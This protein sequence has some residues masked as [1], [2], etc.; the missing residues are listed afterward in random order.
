[1]SFYK[2][3]IFADKVFYH[4]YPLGLSNAPRNND[5]SQPAGNAFEVLESDLDRIRNLGVNALYM[6]PLF[7]STKHGYD[8]IDYYYVDRRLGNN[9]KF[10]HFCDAAHQKGF[11]IVL[12]AVFNH[13]GRD[14]FAFRDLIQNGKNSQYKD[15]FLN[16]NFD[17]QSCYGDCFDYDGWAGCKDLVKL[18]LQNADV[19]NH[20]FGAVKFWM[21][22]F[23]IDGLRLDAADVMDKGFLDK[24]GAFCRENN[25]NFW[26]MGE[27]VHGD[28][29]DWTRDG[30]IDS[31]TNYQIYNSLWASVNELNFF[32]LSFNLNREFSSEKG[33]Y[34]YAPL[35][36]FLDNHDVN[37]LGSVLKNPQKQLYMV[38]GLMFSIPGIPSIYYGSEYGLKGVRNNEGD[39]QLRPSLPPFNPV[40]DYAKPD[41][42]S[43]FLPVA[44]GSFAKVRDSSLAL[45]KGDYQ[46]VFVSNKQFVF[47]RN[48]VGD[49]GEKESVLV[50]CNC[51]SEAATVSLS[52]DLLAQ[53]V[54]S[55]N[56]KADGFK[57]FDLLSGKE[58]EGNVL[59]GI[60]ISS[61]DVKFYKV[62]RYEM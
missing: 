19:Q 59:N 43:A 23:K 30:R 12:D 5:F 10:R 48:Y 53:K 34:R 32:D 28:Y 31:V 7:E 25:P 21:D 24:L 60:K 27:V 57:C 11:A 6:G 35:Y 14:F 61:Y 26:L 56:G 51:D 38:Y 16:I 50:V 44:I 29:N 36:T 1:M 58:Q 62:L 33:L 3:E 20:I 15:W 17:R 49:S 42:D 41:F 18:N 13:T 4:I 22:E 8:T 46:E 39:Y 54:Y 55:L 37:R 2:N 47:A 45:Q 40:P 9:E 52:G